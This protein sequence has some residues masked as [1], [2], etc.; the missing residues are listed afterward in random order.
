MVDFCYTS[1]TLLEGLDQGVQCNDLVNLYLLGDKYIIPS[2][3]KYALETYAT[4]YH[5]DCYFDDFCQSV[6]TLYGCITSPT[7]PLRLEVAD[8]AVND[9][10]DFVYQDQQCQEFLDL[11]T[12]EPEFM[13]DMVR[14]SVKQIQKNKVRPNGEKW[15]V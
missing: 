15:E 9:P 1:D 4:V 3:K 12:D 14:Q 8:L 10:F 6:R 11:A 5:D 2:L 13:L 7:D